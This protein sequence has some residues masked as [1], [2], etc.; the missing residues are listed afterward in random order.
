MPKAIY[1]K[2]TES[3]I[4]A[5][6]AAKKAA[7]SIDDGG[8]AN[9]DSVFLMIPRAREDKVLEAISNAK[10]RCFGRT[11]WIGSGFLIDPPVVGQGNKRA[12]AMVA[13]KDSLAGDG[14]SVLGFYKM[15]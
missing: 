7:E 9:L 12:K 15:D 14:W 3:L 5:S 11:Q 6:E 13:M 4:K 8:T 10:L 1:H 2:L